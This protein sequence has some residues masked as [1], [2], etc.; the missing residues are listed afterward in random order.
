MDAHSLIT[1]VLE[2]DR[3]LREARATALTVDDKR[4]LLRAIDQEV[5]RAFTDKDSAEGGARLM[6]LA[7]LLVDITGPE[8]A[9]LLVRVLGHEEP[10]V[11]VAAGEG[12]VELL[13]D[14]YAEVARVLEAEVERGT[15]VVALSEVPF[16]LAE[17]GE[18]GGVGIVAR[19]LKHADADV[20]G[21][22]I[23]GLAALG[24]ASV[25]KALEPLRNDKRRVTVEDETDGPGEVTLG[26][27]AEEAIAHLRGGGRAG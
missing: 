26:D 9:R 20:V 5:T 6:T 10:A 17:V 21:S 2:A 18:P 8:A 11:R 27:L 25:V 14:R 16:I 13:Y 19:L 3:A 4:A 1:R 15:D 7:D 12:L 22:A 23:E 24:D